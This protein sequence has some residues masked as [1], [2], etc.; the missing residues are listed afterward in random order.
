MVFVR[1]QNIP[2]STFVKSLVN[3]SYLIPVNWYDKLLKFTA[4]H[5]PHSTMPKL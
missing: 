5:S 2:R 4:L 3:L 1:F